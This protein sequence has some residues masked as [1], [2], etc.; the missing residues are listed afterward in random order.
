M[1]VRRH[2]RNRAPEVRAIDRKETAMD[3][4]R[5]VAWVNDATDGMDAAER[6]E[7]LER[8]AQYI[9]TRID[10]AENDAALAGA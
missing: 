5:V 6:L 7:W 8:L 10:I 4:E 1:S 9:E 2:H 3:D